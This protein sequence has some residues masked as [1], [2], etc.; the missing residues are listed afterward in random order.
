MSWTDKVAVRLSLVLI[1][2]VLFFV[3]VFR[4]DQ[5]WWSLRKVNSNNDVWTW[6]FDL[7]FSSKYD[8]DWVSDKVTAQSEKADFSWLT[9]RKKSDKQL[10]SV[11]VLWLDPQKHFVDT[12]WIHWV[13]LDKNVSIQSQSQQ[14]LTWSKLVQIGLYGKKIVW[15]NERIWYPQTVVMIVYL[16]DKTRLLQLRQDVYY[17][18]KKYINRFLQS[19]D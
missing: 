4:R 7:S 10:I 13:Q 6:N 3:Y 1:F 11:A 18:Q 19:L 8:N 14:T 2:T 12:Y 5:R 17:Q 15:V 9:W 16:K